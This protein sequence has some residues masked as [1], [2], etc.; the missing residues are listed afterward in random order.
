[1]K[2]PLS[3]LLAII[4]S[5]C[6]VEREK[7]LVPEQRSIDR[8]EQMSAF[9]SRYK[10]IDWHQKTIDFDQLVYDFS[11]EGEYWP[12]IWLDDT[13]KNLDQTTFGIYTA[14]GDVRQ[15]PSANDGMFHES[16]NSLGSLL[17]ASLVGID[18]S[19][20][21][22]YNFV[23]M[24]QNYFNTDNG[25]NIIMN[26]T[27][28]EVAMLGGGYGRDWWYD[29][30]P[31]LLFY[32]LAYFYPETGITEE[33]QRT[34]AEQFYR[35]DSILDGNYGHSFFDYAAMKGEKNFITNQEDAAAG[36]AYVLY[37]AYKKFG[38]PRYLAGAR[39]ALSAMEQLHEN[40]FYEVL[41]PFGAYVA[42]RL[43]AEESG[44]YDPAMWINW[45]FD[46]A[47]GRQGW[48]VLVDEWNGYDVS[49]LVG[50]LTHNDGYA[51]LMN[52]FDMA[53]PLVPMVRY[54]PAFANAIGKW[55]LH[56]ASAAR[57]MYPAEIP[58]K[59]QTL[60]DKKEVTKNVVAYEGLI[61]HSDFED[62]K[63]I[64]PPVAQGDG[65][66]WVPGKNPD[67]SQFSVYGSGHVGIFGSIIE[68]TNVE[69]ILKL[70]LL[71]TDFYR[72]EALP[73]YLFYNPHNEIQRVELKDHTAQIY[74][75]V[76]K[77]I[78][79]N[80]DGSILIPPA[81]SVVAVFLPDIYKIKEEDG[82]LLINEIIVDY[83]YRKE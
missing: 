68:T 75:A 28:Q 37:C 22:G 5:G 78:F 66:N 69:G 26:N 33:I 12:L 2:F 63:Q 17:G 32:G 34:V 52:T 42:A 59:H 45:S 29:V 16:L 65:P 21:H 76:S 51:F 31:N 38:D 3:I 49:G 83:H 6:G 36:H 80:K 48:G 60:P 77:N 61:H 23:K 4:L 8:I 30:F 41:M 15:G 43:N 14:I 82:K 67:V 54:D 40:R 44:T 57:L 53:W 13:R 25:W 1:M 47:A 62:A 7:P 11:A 64:Q 70:D 74:D 71:A 46:G 35:A 20:Q 79:E 9:P 72:S 55:M 56:A 24:V 27:C 39:S 19:D 18:K 73:T 50:S 10:M 58:D 81:S